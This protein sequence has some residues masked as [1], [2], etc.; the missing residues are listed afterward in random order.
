MLKTGVSPMT[1]PLGCLRVL[2]GLRL[3]QLVAHRAPERSGDPTDNRPVP[4]CFGDGPLACVLSRG[5]EIVWE[6]YSWPDSVVSRHRMF[7]PVRTFT[8]QDAC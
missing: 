7:L 1:A 5:L 6:P 8:G 3:L 2:L 4:A